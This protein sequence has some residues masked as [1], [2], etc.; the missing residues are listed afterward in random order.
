M[1]LEFLDLG[2]PEAVQPVD[3]SVT[4]TRKRPLL[5]KLVRV[6]FLSFANKSPD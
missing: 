1:W 4:G 5:L 6:R 3:F 2:V